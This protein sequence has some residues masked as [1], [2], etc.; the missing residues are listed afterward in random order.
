ML[1]LV[2]CAAVAPVPDDPPAAAA[3]VAIELV[4]VNGLPVV[5]RASGVARRDTPAERA[6]TAAFLDSVRQRFGKRVPARPSEGRPSSG[7]PG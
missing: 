5:V 3:P 2:L 7:G 6:A 1:A 4:R